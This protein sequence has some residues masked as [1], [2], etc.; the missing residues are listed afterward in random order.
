[1]SNQ[2]VTRK[3]KVLN[4]T[5]NVGLKRIRNENFTSTEQKQIRNRVE[6]TK[7]KIKL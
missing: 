2:K 5:E 4:A 3:R 7:Q 6:S 1:M